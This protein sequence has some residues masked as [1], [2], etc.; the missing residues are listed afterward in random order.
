MRNTTTR[1]PLP[2]TALTGIVLV[3]SVCWGTVG[4]QGLSLRAAEWTTAAL[5]PRGDE[6]AAATTLEVGTA[7][8]H[9]SAAADLPPGQDGRATRDLAGVSYR[10]WMSRGRADVGFGLG[11]L[12]FVVPPA[13]GG[14]NGVTTLVGAVPTVTLGVRYRLTDQHLLYVDASRARGL[15]ADPA[16]DVVSTQVGLE[17]RPATSALGFEHGAL[18][19]QLDSG[20]RLSLK[21][22]GGRPALYL[23]GQF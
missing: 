1:R 14:G 20:Y 16:A 21:A 18:G 4:A 23:R 7:R 2:S 8:G 5:N 15:G 17:W 10:V 22:R 6:A 9:F 3:L 11:S 13:A 12:G 19:M